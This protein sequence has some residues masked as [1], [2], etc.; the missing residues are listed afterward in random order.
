M[1]AFGFSS[2]PPHCGSE[3]T[4]SFAVSSPMVTLSSAPYSQPSRT[5][6][7]LAVPSVLRSAPSYVAASD[8]T[9]FRSL[10]KH[11]CFGSTPLLHHLLA[12]SC[13]SSSRP[14]PAFSRLHTVAFG[15]TRLFRVL[16]RTAAYGSFRLFSVSSHRAASWRLSPFRGLLV[17]DPLHPCLSKLGQRLFRVAHLA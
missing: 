5:R 11:G 15:S 17:G 3:S 2:P 1:I 12:H 13:F 6:L 14:F 9:L 7:W 4:L 8:N 10:P 16:S